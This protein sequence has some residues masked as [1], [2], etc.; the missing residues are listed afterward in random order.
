MKVL[1]KRQNKI[2]LISAF[3]SHKSRKALLLH[4]EVMS[5]FTNSKRAGEEVGIRHTSKYFSKLSYVL[6]NTIN[7]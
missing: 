6:M 1:F 2:F 5:N 4:F 7:I 3:A